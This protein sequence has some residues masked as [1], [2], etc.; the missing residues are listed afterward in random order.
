MFLYHNSNY[1]H[2]GCH[3]KK[4]GGT[5]LKNNATDIAAYQTIQH[6]WRFISVLSLHRWIPRSMNKGGRTL[7][8][9]ISPSDL[10][11]LYHL[12]RRLNQRRSSFTKGRHSFETNGTDRFV[13]L[14]N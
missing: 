7:D 14:K 9:L 3:S 13:Y 10:A 4:P 2:L 6:E 12:A 11:E 1:K 8:G 5:A